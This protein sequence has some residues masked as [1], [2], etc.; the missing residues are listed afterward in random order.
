MKSIGIS[1]LF[2]VA[3]IHVFAQSQID[4]SSLPKANYIEKYSCI[5]RW[6]N[7][8]GNIIYVDLRLNEEGKIT[9]SHSLIETTQEQNRSSYVLFPSSGTE[10][11]IFIYKLIKYDINGFEAEDTLLKKKIF[12]WGG[13]D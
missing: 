1:L 9:F 13:E 5:D 12:M 2:I 4:V 8:F 3:S 7:M 10:T 6:G 11:D